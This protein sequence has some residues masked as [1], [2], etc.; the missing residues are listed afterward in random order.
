GDGG[1][2]SQDGGH[3]H[4][5]H[6]HGGHSHGGHSH[7]GHSHGEAVPWPRRPE[8]AFG[9]GRGKTLFFDAFSGVAGDMTIAALVDLGVPTAVIE[10]AV[11][12]LGL[13]GV[14][15]EFRP[16]LV[17]ALGAIHFDVHV[18][19]PQPQRTYA[20]IR[21]LIAGAEGLEPAVRDLA[22]R[23]FLRLAEAES[24][25]HRMPLEAVAFHE[26]GAVDAIVDIVGAAAGL[27]HLGADVVSSPL[28]LGRGFVECQHGRLPL[29]A[30]ATALC[31]RGVPT[32]DA[33]ID[34]EL[35]TPTG[36]A[37]VAAVARDF[38]RWP[39]LVPQAVGWGAGTRRLEDRPNALRLVLGDPRQATDAPPLTH[40]LLEANLD[41]VTGEVA[42]QAVVTLLEQGALDAWVV[43]V[44][45]KKGRP[46]IV[47]TALST[48]RD[49]G[50]LSELILRETP[51]IGV[52]QTLVSRQELPRTVVDVLTPWGPVP[53]KVSGRPPL[54]AKPEFDVC[55]RLSRE[56]G[57]PLRDVLAA[58][59]RAAEEWLEGAR[60]STPGA[61]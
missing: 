12:A 29:P 48:T 58:A 61:P 14:S 10:G 56:R 37:I 41:D 59:A 18:E 13:P 34:V 20:E 28:P 45:M 8:L 31:L 47:L 35:V 40:A 3:S 32:E 38:A 26:V 52:R 2:M 4:G 19:G 39:S 17:G 54:R 1:T 15:L 55:V 33:G 46:G 25:V 9:A 16:V 22:Q 49:A 11:E 60:D 5:G 30:P 24:E 43:P 27:V 42:A 7:G 23:I 21:A 57:V 51:S 53:V 36:A 6:S 44:T 50:R